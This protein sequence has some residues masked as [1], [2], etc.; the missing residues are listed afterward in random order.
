[1]VIFTLSAILLI[2][3]LLPALYQFVRAIRL[4]RQRHDWERLQPKIATISLQDIQGFPDPTRYVLGCVLTDKVGVGKTQSIPTALEHLAAEVDAPTRT[5]RSL[6]YF[7]V[8]IGLLGT[9]TLLALAFWG[10]HQAS[11]LKPEHLRYIYPVNTIA[12][13]LATI[14]YFLYGYFRWCGDRLLLTASQTL[15]SLQSDMPEKVDPK[16]VKALE[17]VAGK[18]REWGEETYARHQQQAEALVREM[19]GLGEAIRGMVNSMIATRRTEEEGIIPLL[20]T[21]DEKVELLSQRLDERFRD[22]AKPLLEGIPIL[23]QWQQRTRELGQTIQELGKADL[24]RQTAELGRATGSLATA[25]TGLPEAIRGQFQG[26]EH[27]VAAAVREAVQA[28]WEETMRPA[29]SSLTAGISSLSE[30]HRTLHESL[31]RLPQVVAR[32]MADSV[33]AGWEQTN[34]ATQATLRHLEAT[35]TKMIETYNGLR[36]TMVL[37]PELVTRGV[38]EGIRPQRDAELLEGLHEL[39]RAA[40]QMGQVTHGLTGAVRDSLGGAGEILSQAVSRSLEG[41]LVN[42]NQNLQLLIARTVDLHTSLHQKLDELAAEMNR[43]GE[44][45]GRTIGQG[46]AEGFRTA[47]DDMAAGH[48]GDIRKALERLEAVLSRGPEE[49]TT[50]SGWLRRR[51]R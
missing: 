40:G 11:D 25:V 6:S 23:E 51:N 48:L 47:V 13:G 35:M 46:A 44:S 8:L 42:V 33:V 21:Q 28:G 19:Q 45:W 29:L 36:E 49:K 43:Q 41:G 20:R 26:I 30:T 34:Q 10:V 4:M 31:D 3:V 1:V 50:W 14:I 5:L 15:G 18:F 27:V 37:I 38:T 32:T 7:S 17:K 22:L 24:P 2:F 16:L 9:V 12:I 39:A